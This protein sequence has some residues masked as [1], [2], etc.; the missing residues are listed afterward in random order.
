MMLRS[1][2]RLIQRMPEHSGQQDPAEQEYEL[3]APRKKIR[4]GTTSCWECKRRKVRCLFT[5]TDPTPSSVLGPISCDGCKR[6][7]TACISQEFPDVSASAPNNLNPADDRLGRV[8]ALVE[9]LVRRSDIPTPPDSVKE[10]EA[11]PELAV[12]SDVDR[13]WN[14]PA[15]NAT[16][17][18]L[19]PRPRPLERYNAPG[20]SHKYDEI[21][22]EL[23]AAWPDTQDLEAIFDAHDPV[24]STGLLRKLASYTLHPNF[25]REH[26][27]SLDARQ[28][29]V[30]PPAG[31]HPVII[32]RKLLLL[33]IFLQYL[34][35]CVAQNRDHHSDTVERC[36]DMMVRVMDTTS[37]LVTSNDDLVGSVEGIECLMLESLYKDTAGSMRRSWVATRRAMTI[38]QMMGLHR[39]RAKILEQETQA[40]FDPQ[41]M[42]FRIVQSDR[43]LS[44][45]L[46]LPLGYSENKF[47]TAKAL[48]GCHLLE[49]LRRLDTVVSGRIIQR[50]DA[51]H[52]GCAAEDNFAATLEIDKL[53]QEASNVMPPNWWLVDDILA[54][55]GNGRS[56]LSDEDSMRI[57]DQIAHYN[58]V[59]QLHLPYLLRHCSDGVFDNN[60]MT[61][62]NASREALRRYVIFRKVYP[63]GA[64]CRGLDFLAFIA[65]A[66]LC[67][68]HMDGQ[69]LKNDM[70][71]ICREPG[72]VSTRGGSS[73][74]ILGSLTHQRPTDRGLMERA[75]ESLEHMGTS[76]SDIL[77][78]KLAS[79][80]RHL[81]VVEQDSAS[82]KSGHYSADLSPEAEYQEHNPGEEGVDEGPSGCNGSI[83]EGGN[84]LNIYI[85]YY[86]TVKIEKLHGVSKASVRAIGGQSVLPG[87]QGAVDMQTTSPTA[88]PSNNI[89]IFDGDNFGGQG[90]PSFDPE[91]AAEADEWTLQGVDMAFFDSLIRGV[92]EGGQE[93]SLEWQL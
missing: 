93:A 48:Q 12:T 2:P 85:P 64:Y 14:L 50:N 17:T 30:L 44:L 81:L 27:P 91:L 62:V 32:A 67:L 79:L 37:R 11:I 47:A 15:P 42:W 10:I 53:L 35:P 6:R 1:R 56:F 20:S 40:R 60:K 57:M 70:H 22:R 18:R 66:A 33:G 25:S 86:G 7:G 36:Q 24:G 21:S 90:F 75:T 43:Y 38:A 82:G 28:V 84:I 29:L 73:S 88:Q 78:S 31:S 58:L 23:I 61:T 16:P 13:Q 5:A 51:C 63:V 3:N 89:F 87:T 9:Q 65:T 74:N 46:G 83:S 72:P 4:K 54:T 49:R 45:M 92:G 69:R 19:T 68:A 80:L 77:A 76:N 59:V 55:D 34:R 26:V 71:P 52:D 39:G 41:H 8:E